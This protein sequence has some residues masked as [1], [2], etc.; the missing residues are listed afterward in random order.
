MFEFVVVC[1]LIRLKI[2]LISTN[3]LFTSLFYHPLPFLFPSYTPHL[4]TKSFVKASK[5]LA[6]TSLI[7][8][9][10]TTSLR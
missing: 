2:T 5:Y 9:L 4:K 6:H 10:V 7:F 1:G 8:V 3:S